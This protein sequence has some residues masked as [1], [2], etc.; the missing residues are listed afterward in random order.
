VDVRIGIIQTVKELDIELPEGTTHD[1]VVAEVDKALAQADGVLWLVDK[2]GRR[3][4]VPS[5]KVA[6]VEIGG[7]GE[8]RRVG[9]G[10]T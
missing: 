6:Y 7:G 9:F 2:R 8:D 10:T 5:A 1:D 3:V 4:A